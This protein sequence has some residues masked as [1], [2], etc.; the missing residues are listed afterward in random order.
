VAA[1]TGAEVRVAAAARTRV[2][3]VGFT[4]SG[5]YVT[6]DSSILSAPRDTATVAFTPALPDTV[7]PGA[8]KIVPFVVDSI[9]QRVLGDTV[10]LAVVAP[11]NVASTPVVTLTLPRRVETDDSL[12]VAATD[13]NGI[14][15]VGFEYR[16][17]SGA[18]VRRAFAVGQRLSSVER[19]LLLGLPITTFPTTVFVRAFAVSASGT[20]GYGAS[21][22]A[23]AGLGDSSVVVAG[24]TKSL[25]DGGTL[26][27]GV[28]HPAHDR[29]YLTNIERNRLEV[30]SIRDSA[31]RDPIVVGSRPWGIVPRPLT[32]TGVPSDTLIVANSGGTNL[33]FVTLRADGS[34]FERLDRYALPNIVAYSVTT[35]RNT[36]TGLLQQ[37]KTVYDFS[38]RPQYLAATCRPPAGGGDACGDVVLVYS[39]TPTGGQTIPFPNKGTIR[40][41]NLA[42]GQSHF[43]FEQ[44]VGRT[45]GKMDTLEIVKYWTSRSPT[46]SLVRDS[47]AIVPY[48]QARTHLPTGVRDTFSIVVDVPKL[49]FRDTTFARNSG[50]FRRAIFGEGGPVAGS[51][52]MYYDADLGLIAV[53][54]G[55]GGPWQF[56]V[57]VF[58]RGISDAHDVSDFIANTFA[59]ISGVALNFDGSLGAVRADSTYLINPA[60]R[61]QGLLQ[62]SGGPGFDFHPRNTFNSLT[63]PATRLAFSAS[64][65]PK[66]D[67]FDTR[68]YR[69]VGSLPVREPIIGPLRSAAGFDGR[70]VLVGATRS[71]VVIVRVPDAFQGSC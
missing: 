49:G 59:R 60:L 30:F 37:M 67:I 40:W 54:S 63:E 6:A 62:S 22:T 5:N 34:G 27:D 28:Y 57:P 7:K 44:A 31:F 21:A 24:Q 25:P 9:G 48:R 61:L 17:R 41:E 66:I 32:R 19:P 35:E 3:I 16:T 11:G 12:V 26:A 29:L 42:T 55:A 70:L 10:T 8:V 2:R 39:T 45:A 47:L 13:P 50:D 23:V 53:D 65:E 20:V 36:G 71:G 68:C 64:A 38:D 1:G 56:Q 14:D 58:D 52:A 33:S 69:V 18:V 4:S 46:G 43:F 51:R 15:T